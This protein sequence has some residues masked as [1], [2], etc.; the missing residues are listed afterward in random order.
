MSGRGKLLAAGIFVLILLVLGTADATLTRE[1]LRLPG[2]FSAE[3]DVIAV[4]EAHGFSVSNTTEQQLLG[5][6]VPNGTVL[7]SRVLLLRNDRAAT[8]A[9]VDSPNVTSYFTELRKVLRPVFSP[10]LR[11]LIDESQPEH[12]KAARDVLSFSDPAIHSDRLLFVQVRNRLYE[13]HVSPGSEAP[14][15]DLLDALTE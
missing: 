10:Q 13:F 2:E 4:S 12:G 3:P 14:V 11:D 6:V 1:T 8:V 7:S 5:A 15:D 9:W